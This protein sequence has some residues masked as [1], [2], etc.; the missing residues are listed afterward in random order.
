LQRSFLSF[1]LEFA[2]ASMRRSVT[3]PS[4][5]W[6]FGGSAR[7]VQEARIKVDKRQLEVASG[8]LFKLRQPVRVA[9]S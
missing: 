8:P 4:W 5:E 2:D 9:M 1:F 3:V 6:F 7:A